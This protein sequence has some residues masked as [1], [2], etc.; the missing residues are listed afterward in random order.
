MKICLVTSF[1]PSREALNEYGFHIA[2]ELRRI[3]GVTLTILLQRYIFRGI[4]ISTGFGG[5]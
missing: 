2:G 5:R 1:P 3:S 4:A